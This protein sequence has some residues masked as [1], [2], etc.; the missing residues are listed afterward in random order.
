[1]SVS[2][3]MV[4]AMLIGGGAGLVVFGIILG[5]AWFF[6]MRKP[7][8]HEAPNR[9]GQQLHLGYEVKPSPL[10]TY[11]SDHEEGFE[12]NLSDLPEKIKTIRVVIS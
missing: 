4:E 10:H 5:L 8:L 11:R 2:L 3:Q 6:G 7:K 1:M 9:S 12:F